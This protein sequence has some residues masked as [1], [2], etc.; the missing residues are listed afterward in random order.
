MID[1]ICGYEPDTNPSDP[2]DTRI[3]TP[4]VIEWR[5]RLGGMETLRRVSPSQRP[6]LANSS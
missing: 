5:I 3:Q 2:Q 1:W 4:L 6:R